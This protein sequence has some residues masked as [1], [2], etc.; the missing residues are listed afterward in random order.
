MP[1]VAI[2][3]DI[4][5]PKGILHGRI[6]VEG[7]TI[8]GFEE[9]EGEYGA[10]WVLPGLVDIHNH[11]CGGSNDVAGYWERPEV[12][13]TALARSGT[14]SCLASVVV[15][16][17]LGCVERAIASLCSHVETCGDNEARLLGIHAEGPIINDLGGL[18]ES[19]FSPSDPSQLDAFVGKMNGVCKI[20]TVSPSICSSAVMRVLN[21]HGV[22]PGLGHDRDCSQ[23]SVENCLNAAGMRCHMTHLFNVMSFDHKKGTLPHFGLLREV[24]GDTGPLQTPTVEIIADGIHLHPLTVDLV[25]QCRSPSD[26][27]VVTDCIAPNV[28]HKELTYNSREM[29]VSP[30][31]GCYLKGSDTLAGSTATLFTS[32]KHLVTERNL[33]LTDAVKIFAETPA[34][35]AQAEHVGVLAKGK[36]ADLILVEKETFS[37]RA[38]MIGGR[39]VQRLNTSL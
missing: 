3:G 27:A 26:I 24:L 28:P 19:D 14:T 34:R 6:L 5:T 29:Y 21:N 2:E 16:K 9:D 23:V 7:D 11:G 17:D 37:L 32:M 22:R 36:K 18:P 4:V 33:P 1:P 35:I 8:V 38:V 20:M 39:W 15:G 25:L 31:G 10:C 12:S 13:L 30:N